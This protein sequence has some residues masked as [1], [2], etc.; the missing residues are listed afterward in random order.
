GV[1]SA[2]ARALGSGDAP[3]ARRLVMHALVIATAMGLAFTALV[4]PFGPALYGLLG[5]RD[6]ALE[7]ALAYSGV[8]F[9]GA[10]V[11]WLA[12]TLSAVLRG[13]GNM[14]L[15]AAALVGAALMHL[16][17]SAAL[18]LGLGPAPQLGIAGAG[19]AY[20][21]TFGVAALVMAGAVL[22]RGSALRPRAGDWRL[23]VALFREILRVGAISVVSSIQ[24]VLTS[25]ILTGL[26]GRH[27]A[28]A[29]AGYGV[30]L[31][32]ELLQ[33][34]LVFAVG[35]ALVVLVGTHIGAG[36]PQRAKR[37]AWTGAALAASLSLAIAVVV[38]LVPRL[39]VGIFSADP[40]VLDAGALY[41]RVVAPFFPFLAAAM[42][43]YFASQGAGQV[44]L[45]VL[46]G[47]ARLVIVAAGGALVGSL[48]GIFAVIA[49][50]LAVFGATTMA[51]V[52]RARWG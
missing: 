6:E 23:E 19:V 7:Q 24:T 52:W 27:G 12:N 4:L 1:S 51:A 22:R 26:V 5:G 47:T 2:I 11:V 42:A 49:L 17:L 35:Q 31:R 13:T 16:P 9:A 21:A 25:V 30:G 18:V 32:L 40:E 10:I 39:W 8:V 15:P 34:P 3:R 20:V 44:L 46:S 14:A 41:L 28:A 29:L 33:L 36:Q 38:T 50:G 37:I 45:P 48:G 43:L